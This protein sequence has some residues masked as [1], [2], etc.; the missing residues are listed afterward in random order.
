MENRI[1][2]FQD[3]AAGRENVWLPSRYEGAVAE[4]VMKEYQADKVKGYISN[5]KYRWKPEQNKRDE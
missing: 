2:Q 4:K 1:L 5:L 3:A